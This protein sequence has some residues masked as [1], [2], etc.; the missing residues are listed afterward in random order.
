MKNFNR[1]VFF[2]GAY[3]SYQYIKDYGSQLYLSLYQKPFSPT[4]E[5]GANQWALVTGSSD[6]LGKGIADNLSRLK[7]NVILVSRTRS[8]MEKIKEELE[9]R[10][11]TQIE[12]IEFDFS[13]T[14]NADAYQK[15]K[16][17]IQKKNVRLLVHNVGMASERFRFLE[18]QGKQIEMLIKTN[19]YAQLLLSKAFLS[20]QKSQT[21]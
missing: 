7:M 18:M 17:E 20:F 1:I 8:K 14:Y 6:G 3:R 9:A 16:D 19:T 11:K 4:E 10:D 13:R 21:P 5:Y 12:I 2:V 15:I